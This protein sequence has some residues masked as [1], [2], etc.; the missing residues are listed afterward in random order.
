MAAAQVS[1]T[2]S[3]VA[4]GTY[5]RDNWPATAAYLGS[6]DGL[7]VDAAGN[8]YVSDA[9][10]HRIRKIDRE[11]IITTVAGDGHPGFGGDGGPARLAQLNSPYGLAMDPAGNLYVADL[12]NHRVRVISAADGRIRTV[13]GGGAAEGAGDAAG[14]LLSQPR[15]L[16]LD[17]AGN[18]YIS[19]FGRHRVYRVTPGADIEPVA[20]VCEPGGIED[21]ETVVAEFAHLN[22]PAGLAV[23]RN[24]ALYIADSGNDRI[25]KVERGL[26]T[27]VDAGELD[28]PT[29]LAFD[30]S[31]KLY[32]ADRK[33]VARVTPAPETVDTGGALAAHDVAFDGRG[34]LLIAGRL[35]EAGTVEA[36]A[37]DGTVAIIAGGTTFQPLGD[38]GPPERAHLDGPSAVAL[39]PNGELYIADRYANR[40]RKVENGL[41]RTVA[42]T[43]ERGPD[44]D[45]GPATEAS[46]GGPVGLAFD[47]GSGWYMA[48]AAGNRVRRVDAN[49]RI[50]RV[51]GLAG[52]DAGY[53]G[54][55]A[56]AVFARLGHPEGVA[57]DSAGGLY[58]A[59]TENHVVRRVSPDGTIETVAGKGVPGYTGDGGPARNALF[60]EPRGVSVD[61][62]GR[63][64]VA[65]TSNNAIRR[66]GLDGRVETVLGGL[67]WPSR[68]VAGENGEVYIADTNNH[69]ILR[70]SETGAL[71]TIAGTGIR[72]FSGDGGPA[73]DAQ[74]SEPTDVALDTAG[75]IYV[76]DRGNN[77]VRKL[78]RAG[79]VA[80]PPGAADLV[81]AASLLG[82]PVAPGEVVLIVG[83]GLGASTPESW[84]RPETQVAGTLVLFDGV[85]APLLYVGP[86]RLY[87][88]VPDEV[89]GRD[90][91][92]V[93]VRRGEAVQARLAAAVA[94]A[95]P[96]IY[97]AEGGSSRA[98]ALNEDGSWNGA[99][100]PAR[101]GS[102]LTFYATGEG[103]SLDGIP[104][105]PVTVRMGAAGAEVREARTATGLA[106]VMQIK[107]GV[108]LEVTSGAVA[109]EMKVG[110][111]ASQPGVSVWVE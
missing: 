57:R 88:Q 92:Q 44:G 80:P 72:G 17:A 19:D 52:A 16:A 7:A 73:V 71:T 62:L 70:R 48:E 39:G 53:S 5:C 10:D 56:A 51:A 45:G 101:R 15:N 63:V 36:R 49:G 82:G 60:N 103:R 85:A 94:V 25:R 89:S 3:T 108:P 12:W 26:M 42:G 87:V 27:T 100:S 96:G 106:G 9:V 107:A 84:G 14:A 43:G 110:E 111:A 67:W 68:A 23:D 79:T 4:G 76:A 11:G 41:I 93:E 78:T 95:A 28:L 38:D 31:G 105:L 99:V 61:S 21:G 8:I 13:A 83:E 102:V 74:L 34:N 98:L 22:A 32:V 81:N 86:D 46:L 1:Y 18:L 30:A 55:G 33:G 37:S 59:D 2:I 97:T 54:D 77:L 40:V 29:G 35:G 104:V 24:G 65:D 75:N 20:G 91:T 69:R 66:I 58:I 64:Y 50:E 6:P 47:G 109:V 90:T